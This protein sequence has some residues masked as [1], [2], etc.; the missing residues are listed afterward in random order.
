MTETR[1]EATLHSPLGRGVHDEDD[2]AL[3]LGKVELLVAGA[4]GLEAV[5]RGVG[6]GRWRG[7]ERTVGIGE[8]SD[9]ARA[10]DW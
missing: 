10:G 7:E 2:L 4:R 5:E 8:L 3:E 1:D 9:R 6:H